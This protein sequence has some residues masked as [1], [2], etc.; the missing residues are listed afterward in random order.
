[1]INFTVLFR[2]LFFYFL[3]GVSALCCLVLLITTKNRD[4]RRKTAFGIVVA[5]TLLAY[6]VFNNYRSEKI[7]EQDE[8]GVY[9]LTDYPGCYLCTLE[10][11][12]NNVFVVRQRNSI[13]ETGTWR[14]ESGRDYWITYL[15]KYDQ[16]GSGKYRYKEYH[17]KHSR[18]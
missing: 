17:L 10:L 4:K 15:N 8:L 3:P 16:L 9:Q 12:E 14:Y 5:T 18:Q 7:A 11:Q 2:L 6:F 1:M 13:R